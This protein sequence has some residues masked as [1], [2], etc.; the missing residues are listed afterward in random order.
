MSSANYDAFLARVLRNAREEFA[1]ITPDYP[2]DLPAEL[3]WVM[4]SALLAEKHIGLKAAGQVV[5]DYCVRRGKDIPKILNSPGPQ[6]R[7]EESSGGMPPPFPR[8]G[9]CSRH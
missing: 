6:A 8:P 5:H 4:V 7:E 2:Y 3:V 1:F 9:P